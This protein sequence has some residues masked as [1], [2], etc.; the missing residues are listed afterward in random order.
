MN[1]MIWNYRI[2]KSIIHVVGM[3]ITVS[4]LS[5]CY[6]TGMVIENRTKESI[7]V[8]SGHTETTKTIRSGNTAEISHTEGPI[9]I[10]AGDGP[11]WHYDLSWFDDKLSNDRYL[12]KHPILYKSTLC[13]L[14]ETNGSLF[15][16]PT[17]FWGWDDKNFRSKQPDGYPLRPK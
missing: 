4:F 8:Y 3:L 1:F 11:T 13:F 14:V 9:T 17:T 10:R 2:H 6:I 5:G 12:R 16:L 7:T 15:V